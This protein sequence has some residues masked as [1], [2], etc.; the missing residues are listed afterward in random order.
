[1]KKTILCVV[2]CFLIV[3]FA[4]GI[5]WLIGWISQANAEPTPD[6]P[7]VHTCEF[8]EWSEVLAPT[9]TTPGQARRT[10]VCGLCE[11]HEVASF[12]HN[13]VDGIC[14]RCGEAD[15][16]YIPP[17]SHSNTRSETTLAETCTST[18]SRDTY[19]E[20]CGEFLRTETIPKHEHTTYYVTTSVATCTSGGTKK[21]Y[22]EECGQLLD[23]LT[24]SALGHDHINGI[25]S[26]CGMNDPSVYALTVSMQSTS[27]GYYMFTNSVSQTTEAKLIWQS[28][29]GTSNMIASSVVYF[30]ATFTRNGSSMTLGDSKSLNGYTSPISNTIST[31][32][33]SMSSSYSSFFVNG[34][35][36]VQFKFIVGGKTYESNN[37]A[38]TYDKNNAYWFTV[39]AS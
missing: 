5:C 26:R 24:T 30:T 28:G 19:C 20:D 4:F 36:T 13:Y 35:Y 8:G 6:T 2:G 18:G 16:D 10:C 39:S 23:T 21:Q 38:F 14:S 11:E 3:A 9:C 7:P 31:T 15:P 22:C 12:G 17:C 34:E 27:K 25:C 37:F 33:M 1:M 29:A 32:A